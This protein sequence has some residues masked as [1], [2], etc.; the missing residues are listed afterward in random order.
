MK[1]KLFFNFFIALFMLIVAIGCGT[2]TTLVYCKPDNVIEIREMIL[3]ELELKNTS[4]LDVPKEVV[5]NIII[6]N[7][8]LAYLKEGIDLRVDD[9]SSENIP[10]MKIL[11][12]GKKNDFLEK[13]EYFSM[14]YKVYWKGEN[15]F[16]I[17]QDFNVG[18]FFLENRKL[19]ESIVES[20]RCI[21][22]GIKK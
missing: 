8:K 12:L 5:S 3:T 19:N 2:R 4:I 1:R 21:K 16:Y 7:L 22:R 6:E 17:I 11:L 9:C 10:E 13:K 14:I 20:V 18:D 15:I